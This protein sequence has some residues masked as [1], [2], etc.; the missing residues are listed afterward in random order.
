MKRYALEIYL[1][2][3]PGSDTACTIE[4]DEPFLPI[5]RGDLIN[6]RTWT[7]HYFNNL[8]GSL[9]EGEYPYG[10]LLRVT[11]VEHFLI[12]RE[13]GFSQHRLGVFTEAVSDTA[14]SRP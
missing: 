9:D 12:Q 4:A 1:P 13:E 3:N 10:V 8:R 2:Q 7:S 5:Q 11:G 14:E 6:P